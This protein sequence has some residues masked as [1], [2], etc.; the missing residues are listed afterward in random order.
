[1][2]VGK[3]QHKNK[4][5]KPLK[6]GRHFHYSNLDSYPVDAKIINWAPLLARLNGLVQW[7]EKKQ[8]TLV[9]IYGHGLPK[10]RLIKTDPKGENT[11]T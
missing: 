5:K 9:C 8:F 4:S 3:K 10:D 7:W 1:M 6:L 2:P 11:Y